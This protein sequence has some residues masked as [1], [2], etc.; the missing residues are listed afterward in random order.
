VLTK[1]K[2][3]HSLGSGEA[4]A[5][6]IITSANLQNNNN[7]MKKGAAEASKTAI[8]HQTPSK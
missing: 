4:N 3:E 2:K 5:E 8:D 7:K 1:R 6:S